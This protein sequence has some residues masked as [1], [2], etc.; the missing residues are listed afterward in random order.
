[1]IKPYGSEKSIFQ[2]TTLNLQFLKF[3]LP[4]HTILASEFGKLLCSKPKENLEKDM[5]KP[6]A[7]VEAW[8]EGKNCIKLPIL[9]C[10]VITPDCVHDIM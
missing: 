10:L 1:M 7:A 4:T 3:Y 8:P 5:T 2:N 9:K 6:S